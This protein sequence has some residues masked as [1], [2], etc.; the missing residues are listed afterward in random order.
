MIRTVTTASSRAHTRA[1]PLAASWPAH[2]IVRAHGEI[3]IATSPALRMRLRNAMRRSENVLIL[4]L[5]DV[6]FCDASGLAV[7]VG[8]QRRARQ[9]GITLRLAA[10]SRRMTRL[11]QI[12]DLDQSFTI[13]PTLSSAIASTRRE[14]LA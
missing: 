10:P 14:T 8:I 11:L 5:S 1:R 9:C 4:D 13:H 3:D 7:L 12:T 2:T 6:S